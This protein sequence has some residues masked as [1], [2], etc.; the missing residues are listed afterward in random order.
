MTTAERQI[1]ALRCFKES[2]KRQRYQMKL[3]QKKHIKDLIYMYNADL[4]PGEAPITAKEMYGQLER[5]VRL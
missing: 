1:Q 4:L 5:K 3:D 2:T